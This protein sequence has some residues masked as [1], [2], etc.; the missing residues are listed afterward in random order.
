MKILRASVTDL[1][2]S[3]GYIAAPYLVVHVDEEP[4]IT[5]DAIIGSSPGPQLTFVQHG[6]F[7]HIE[8]HTSALMSEEEVAGYANSSNPTRY[9]KVVPIE[10][11]LNDASVG[12]M[13]MAVSRARQLLRKNDL[14]Y[15]YTLSDSAARRGRIQW[16]LELG[17]PMCMYWIG[18]S[19]C[20][21]DRVYEVIQLHATQM[22]ACR[23]HIGQLRHEA[24]H[25]RL[26]RTGRTR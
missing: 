17:H 11:H 7:Q 2:R 12:S 4:K 5:G 21:E 3:E 22:P 23:D 13:F 14:E 18:D 20:G 19:V 8:A 15:Q 24:R 16:D 1:R 9:G 26:Q 6:P 10:V 25:L